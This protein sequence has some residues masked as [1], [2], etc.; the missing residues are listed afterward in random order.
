M[1]EQNW[2]KRMLPPLLLDM[3]SSWDK[4]AQVNLSVEGVTVRMLSTLPNL[5][6][7]STAAAGTAPHVQPLT[8]ATG[9]GSQQGDH[10][11]SSQMVRIRSVLQA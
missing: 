8:D 4:V 6:S 9:L 3:K 7:V 10:P 2:F 5:Q 11:S 1:V